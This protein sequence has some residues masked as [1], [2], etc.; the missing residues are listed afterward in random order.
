MPNYI[1]RKNTIYEI[2]KKYEAREYTGDIINFYQKLPNGLSEFAGSV[3]VPIN[4]FRS[5]DPPCRAREN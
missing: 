1:S 4:E 3:F 5:S 2:W